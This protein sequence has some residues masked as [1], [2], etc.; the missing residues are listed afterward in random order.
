MTENNHILITG[1]SSGIG[2]ALA[3][4]YAGPG[5]TLSLCGRDKQRL[6]EVAGA[7][8]AKGADVDA[9]LM[10]VTDREGMRRWI[11]TRDAVAPL[12][13][14][15]ANAG[16]GDTGGNT[17]T[18]FAINI[19]GVLNTIDPAI[20][21]MTNHGGGQIALVSS[22]SGYRGLP[23]CAP[24]SASKGFIKLYGEGLRGALATSG[25]RVNV[26][27]PGFVR[28]RITDQNTCPMPFFMEAERAAGIIAK[29]LHKN[30]G[31]IAFPWPMTLALWFLSALPD[32]L[33]GWITR[34]FPAKN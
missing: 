23:H 9:T 17:E 8:R 15:I 6:N 2:A 22:L 7:S 11:N 20:E 28:S 30:K 5:V 21:L 14:I 18:L 1:A 16:V 34:H 25:I 31:L 3:I 13:L 33:A 10:D 19:N 26:I 4:H 32:W 29:G 24:Y 27:C 12:T